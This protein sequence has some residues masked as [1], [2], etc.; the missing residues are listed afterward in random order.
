MMN[1]EECYMKN[2]NNSF[3]RQIIKEAFPDVKC[4]SHATASSVFP[5]AQ[6][7]IFG[8]NFSIEGEDSD[9]L[10]YWSGQFQHKVRPSLDITKPNCD[11]VTWLKD[12]VE[13]IIKQNTD[14]E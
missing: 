8:I 7:T 12:H 9:I 6:F 1:K 13:K 10:L 11:P 14:C 2:K 5:T 4:Y 3:L